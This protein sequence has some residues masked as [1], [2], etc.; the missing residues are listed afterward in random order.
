MMMNMNVN[1]MNME[2]SR[3]HFVP[4]GSAKKS[5]TSTEDARLL[6]LIEQYGA[7]SWSVIAEKLVNRTGKQCRERYHNH[8]N[9]D[10]KKGEWSEAED[11]ILQELHAQLGN[12][13]AKIAKSLPGRTDNSIKNRWH[14]AHRPMMMDDVEP[15]GSCSFSQAPSN[16]MAMKP[17]KVASSSRAMFLV[18]S[19]NLSNVSV[20]EDMDAYHHSHHC[21]EATLSSRSDSSDDSPSNASTSSN[22]ETVQ[23]PKSARSRAFSDVAA[24]YS[25]SARM[26]ASGV[27]A[28]PCL[29]YWMNKKQLNLKLT[30][31]LHDL[32][33][34]DAFL[35]ARV[36]CREEDCDNVDARSASCDADTDSESAEDV[37][38]DVCEPAMAPYSFSQSLRLD[39]DS[40]DCSPVSTESTFFGDDAVDDEDMGHLGFAFS[41][42]VENGDMS[43]VYMRQYAPSP[44]RKAMKGA[45]GFSKAKLSSSNDCQRSPFVPSPSVA[46]LQKKRRV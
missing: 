5:W 37:S 2:P 22:T 25:Q 6:E 24:I 32:D 13:W 40:L 33:C 1:L 36:V 10:V 29:Q 38:I 11:I 31:H 45:A 8:L 7:S 18:P 20:D 17:V 23:W 46:M 35:T 34:S 15:A 39:L 30:Q 3:Q 14:T 16:T 27:A 9:P 4:R 28:S 42:D 12:Q 21:H 44:V 26:L 43:D 19:L 41:K